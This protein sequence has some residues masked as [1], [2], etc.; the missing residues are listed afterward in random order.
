MYSSSSLWQAGIWISTPWHLRQQKSGNTSHSNFPFNSYYFH[1]AGWHILHNNGSFFF[2]PPIPQLTSLLTLITSKI[3]SNTKN[4]QYFLLFFLSY[5]SVYGVL[6]AVYWLMT[7]LDM[8]LNFHMKWCVCCL[9]SNQEHHESKQRGKKQK[10]KKRK[11]PDIQT[12][13]ALFAWIQFLC[14]R[15]ASDLQAL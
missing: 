5:S 6:L 1:S 3:S 15:E 14:T 9:H 12:K 2:L 10:G 11:L 8:R 7:F 13:I 4:I